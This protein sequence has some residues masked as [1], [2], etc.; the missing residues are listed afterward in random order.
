MKIAALLLCCALQL[1][2]IPKIVF[3]K[4]FPGS[5]P[6]YVSVSVNRDGALEYKESPTDDQPLKAQ[7]QKAEAAQLFDLA[8]KL[9]YFKTPLESGLKVANTG[10]KTFRYEGESGPPSETIF[11]YSTNP[12]GQQLLDRFEQIAA[13]ERAYLELDRTIHFDKLGVNDALAEIESL[14]LKKELASPEQFVPL[15]TR[16][17]SHE[18]FMHIARERAARLKDE[19]TAPPPIAQASK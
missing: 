2:A 6:E 13:T 16:V 14:W 1:C 17:A 19:F 10:K 8:E 4:S 15:L 12:L 7:L 11:N 5:S 18:S 9:D 3:T